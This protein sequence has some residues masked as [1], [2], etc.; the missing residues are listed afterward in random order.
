MSIK[1]AFLSPWPELAELVKQIA[2]ERNESV[3]ILDSDK[4][5]EELCRKERIEVI[6]ARGPSVNILRKNTSIP[7]INCEPTAF[8]VLNAFSNA[9]QYDSDIGFINSWK[10]FFDKEIVEKIL[11]IK[12]QK[13]AECNSEEDIY[14]EV[15]LAS[16][17][18]LKVVVGGTVTYKI[19]PAFDIKCIKLLVSKQAIIES[20]EKAKE[21]VRVIQE[22]QAE[23]E[24]FRIILDMEENGIIS[25]DENKIVTLFNP[26]AEKMTGIN[27]DTIIGK[28]IEK[29]PFLK[30]I[31]DVLRQKKNI[32][33]EIVTLGNVKAINTRVPILV[34]DKVVGVVSTYQDITKLQETETKVRKELNK[35]GF[36]AKH[37]LNK[38]IGNS[39]KFNK[40]IAAAEAYAQ[41]DSTILIIGETGC[42]KGLLAQGIHLA[43]CRSNGP[44]VAVNCS[45]L[46]ENLLESE[47]FGYEEGAFTGARR[48]GKQG[49]FELAHNGTLFLDEIAGTSLHMQSRLLKVVEE[50]EVMRVGGVQVIPLDVRIIAAS[51]KE[52]RKEISQ[53]KFRADLF[54]RLNVLSLKV[55]PLRERKE[56][57]GLLFRHFLNSRGF[58]DNEIEAVLDKEFSSKLEKYYWPG[59]VRELQHFVEKTVALCQGGASDLIADM[60]KT[61][62]SELHDL[63]DLNYDSDETNGIQIPIGT[64]EEMENEIIRSLYRKYY[65]NKTR[66]A[67]QLDISRT[68]L[69]KRLD[70]ILH[71]EVLSERNV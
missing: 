32:N 25:I 58:T 17:K 28:P 51:N 23:M 27:K 33:E 44:F 68:T 71:G 40:V 29:F 70:N 69:W 67:E 6:I 62:L 26:M 2:D 13:S 46:P 60:R 37:E 49:L 64:L 21:A 50:M 63:Q 61:I 20:F 47:L 59:N 36:T 1:M 22:K 4:I 10:T 43:S 55:P 3:A 31:G 7:V 18:G 30:P 34:E 8:D 38:I 66:L 41:K 54:Y 35:K 57:I 19:A 45:A 15:E 48:G 53:G 65:G 24:R 14:R 5:S 12:I 11:E 16:D 9:R 56:D 39:E 52:L 42:G